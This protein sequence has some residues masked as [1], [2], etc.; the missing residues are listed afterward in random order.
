MRKK[1]VLITNIIAPYR[2]SVFNSISKYSDVDLKVIFLAEKE[3]NRKWKI[4]LDDIRFN[5][6]ILKNFCIFIRSWEMPI[7]FNLGFWQILTNFKPDAICMCGYHYLVTI[8][9]LLY[10]KIKKIPITLWAESHLL[11]GFIKNPLTDFY[12]RNIISRFDSYVACGT[13]AK[14]QIIYYG[15]KPEKTVVGC[16]TVD[17][18]W[19][20]RKCKEIQDNEIIQ[21]KRRYPSQNIIYVGKFIAH[22]GVLNLIAEFEKLDMADVGLILLGEGK[23]KDKY[24]E[25]IRK[26]DIKNVFF[27]GFVQKEAIV[28]YYKLADVFVLPSFNEVWG[29]VVNEAMACGLP[30]ISSNYAGVTEDL[31]KDG[32]NGYSYNPNKIGELAEKLKFILSNNELKEKMRAQSLEII[33]DKTTDNYAE[34]ILEAVRYG[35]QKDL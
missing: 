5:Y 12:K 6:S 18:E 10:A 35:L 24:L 32:I 16:N 33:K 19:F 30:V 34:K 20:M 4:N 13:A 9:A 7:Y 31:V 28:T 23:E 27:E 29:F 21:M 22:K 14:E 26:H 15:A 1:I 17:V 8:E 25:Y 2:I 3:S 11:S